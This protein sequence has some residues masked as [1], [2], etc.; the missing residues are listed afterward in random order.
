MVIVKKDKGEASTI[1]L[2]KFLINFLID[3]VV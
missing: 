2:I 1:L 3:K